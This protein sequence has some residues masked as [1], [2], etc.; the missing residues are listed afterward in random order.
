MLRK[1]KLKLWRMFKEFSEIQN[2]L[3]SSKNVRIL[4]K[5]K[6][7]SLKIFQ[8]ISG[9]QNFLIYPGLQDLEKSWEFY[10]CKSFFLNSRFPDS[11]KISRSNENFKITF[12]TIFSIFFEEFIILI[13]SCFQK[14]WKAIKAF[15]AHGFKVYQG[16][17]C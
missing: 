14:M 7:P 5:L 2:F 17:T 15:I 10:F 8:E 6:V 9:I 13:L 3:M 11:I 12:G 16:F 1:L 4:R